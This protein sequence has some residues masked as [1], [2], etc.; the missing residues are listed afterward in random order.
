MIVMRTC[1][2]CVQFA[3]DD[4]KDV[5]RRL[6]LSSVRHVRLCGVDIDDLLTALLSAHHVVE[7][8]VASEQLHLHYLI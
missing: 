4:I 5:T 6:R 1:L 3:V 2:V 8:T 7:V